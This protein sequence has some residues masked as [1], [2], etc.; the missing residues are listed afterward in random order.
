MLEYGKAKQTSV[1]AYICPKDPGGLNKGNLKYNPS[2]LLKMVGK[3]QKQ[4]SQTV[5]YW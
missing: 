4:I 2:D 3:S 5:A 1:R